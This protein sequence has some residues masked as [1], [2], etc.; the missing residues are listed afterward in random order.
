[1]SMA[2]DLTTTTVLVDFDLRHPTIHEYLGLS[3]KHNLD[4][5][6]T[7]RAELNSLMVNPMGL[8]RLG[9]LPNR[10]TLAARE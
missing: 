5:W 7:Q 3:L 6:L 1:M 2:R 9:L 10:T 4:D 8:D